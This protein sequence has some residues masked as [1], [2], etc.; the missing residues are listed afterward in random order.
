MPNTRLTSF[1]CTYNL[2]NYNASDDAT[3]TA[4]GVKSFCDVSD[5]VND[6][7]SYSYMTLEHNY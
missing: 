7:V 3:I 1:E 4:T 5:L 6:N 2:I